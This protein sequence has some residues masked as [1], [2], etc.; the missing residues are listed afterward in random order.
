MGVGGGENLRGQGSDR[1]GGGRGLDQDGGAEGRESLQ[2]LMNSQVGANRICRQAGWGTREWDQDACKGESL[3]EKGP[4]QKLPPVPV[5]TC[6]PTS[7]WGLP[8]GPLSC[9]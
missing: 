5:R 6:Y 9:L 1:A 3:S 2:I 8:R 4:T 7:P